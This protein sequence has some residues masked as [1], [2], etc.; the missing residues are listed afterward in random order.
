MG[1]TA[2]ISRPMY[3]KSFFILLMGG[4]MKEKALA[5]FIYDLCVLGRED[6]IINSDFLELLY[7]YIST[8]L[9]SEFFCVTKFFDVIEEN[10]N[11]V[12][13]L[14]FDRINRACEIVRCVSLNKKDFSVMFDSISFEDAQEIG[15][16][17]VGFSSYLDKIEQIMYEIESNPYKLIKN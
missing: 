2:G 7:Q 8:Y 5:I 15:K 17:A 9:E 13:N 3:F 1:G 11:Y 16:F 14:P 12:L 10:D 6:L 4:F